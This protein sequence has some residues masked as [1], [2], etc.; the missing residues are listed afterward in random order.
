METYFTEASSSKALQEQKYPLPW[1]KNHSI[2]LR[3]WIP[4]VSSY[5]HKLKNVKEL[6]QEKETLLGLITLHYDKEHFL[7]RHIYY[8]R[9]CLQALPQVTALLSPQSL[10]VFDMSRG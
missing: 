8:A 10:I 1:R 3:V 7:P 2:A 4:R 6:A 9:I 5:T